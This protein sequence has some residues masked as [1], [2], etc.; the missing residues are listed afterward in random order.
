VAAHRFTGATHQAN[1]R[2]PGIEQDSDEA[3]EATYRDRLCALCLNEGKLSS[4]KTSQ[5]N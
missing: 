4:D 5:P 2:L 1:V 3:A